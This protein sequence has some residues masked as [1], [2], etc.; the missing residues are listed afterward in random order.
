MRIIKFL[1]LILLL[2]LFYPLFSHA[3]TE[4]YDSLLRVEQ[5]ALVEPLKYIDLLAIEDP[6]THSKTTSVLF[7]K[8]LLARLYSFHGDVTL[9]KTTFDSVFHQLPENNVWLRGYWMLYRSSLSLEEGKLPQ[10]IKQIDQAIALFERVND[11]KML[12]RARTSKA[13]LL[14]WQEDYALSIE[15]LEAAY[16]VSKTMKIPEETM[17]YVYLGFAAYYTSMSIFDQAIKFAELAKDNVVNNGD[18]VNGLPIISLLCT[19]YERAHKLELA[20]S[21]YDQMIDL[22]VSVKV[23]RYLFW[24]PAGKASVAIKQNNYSEA[25]KLLYLAKS[26]LPDLAINPAHIVALFNN[27]A[28]TF[29]A[30]NQPD[31]ALEYLQNSEKLLQQYERP[32]NNRYKR[33]TLLLKAKSLELKR[34]Y[35][36]ANES[37]WLF[38]DLVEEAKLSTQQKLEQEARSKFESSQQE[39]KLQLAEEKLK[40]QQIEL[41]RL[42]KDAQLK[43]AYLV[44]GFLAFVSISIFT[45][46]QHKAFRKSQDRA[47]T[48]ALTG[49][50]NRRYILDYVLK[51]WLDKEKLFA[52]AILDIDHF[53][54]VNDQYGH[55]IGD[56]ALIG[57]THTLKQY[58]NNTECKYARFGGEEFLVVMPGYDVQRATALI[59]GLCDLIRETI[60]TD[61]NISITSSAGISQYIKGIQLNAILKQA[62]KKLYEAKN[63]GRDKVCG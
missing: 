51:K 19:T 39:I 11:L 24:A 3:S 46:N 29:L 9:S 25:L 62:D 38:I 47:N 4:Q 6:A 12:I 60:Y 52:V 61:Q 55:D 1:I 48:D 16:L 33:N 20:N 57:F 10:A 32:L 49:A 34:D 8:V 54:S 50:P 59:T 14:L 15:L 27:F 53:K 58:F 43:M 30:L 42:E 23:P 22:S 5:Q 56:Q 40:N 21:C 37:L 26:Y 45:Y 17:D 28:K 18:V 63:T 31:Q 44:I 13:V 7:N 36:K 35:S 2:C 41:E